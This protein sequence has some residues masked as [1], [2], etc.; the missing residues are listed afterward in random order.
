[1]VVTVQVHAIVGFSV[2]G[3]TLATLFTHYPIVWTVKRLAFGT[4]VLA[5]LSVLFFF[6]TMRPF[7]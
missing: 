4:R 3:N 6:N 7:I 2:Y 5:V 1:M